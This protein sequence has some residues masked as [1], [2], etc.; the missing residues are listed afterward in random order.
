MGIIFKV[1]DV[2]IRSIHSRDKFWRQACEKKLHG[3]ADKFTVEAVSSS[4]R[5]VS[6]KGLEGNWA[7]HRFTKVCIQVRTSTQVGD[8]VIRNR[9]SLDRTWERECKKYGKDVN[10]QFKVTSIS[11]SGLLMEVEGLSG[12]WYPSKFTKVEE[13]P[14]VNYQI[15][16]GDTVTRTSGK[17]SIGWVDS[18]RANGFVKDAL[19]TVQ[20]SDTHNLLLKELNG[21]WDTDDFTVVQKRRESIPMPQADMVNHPKHYQVFPDL[22]AIEIIARSMTEE[23]FRGYCLGNALKYR[24]RAGKKDDVKQDLAK[25]ETYA[26]IFE[27]NKKYCH[28]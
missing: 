9:D 22:E 13:K 6:L 5:L 26:R 23:M 19:F 17:Y 16:A 20:E 1:G 27:E 12:N 3:M 2:V 18:C 28:K 7:T 25:A 4:G 21:L 11:E 15:K 10:Q 8:T 24:L 14:T